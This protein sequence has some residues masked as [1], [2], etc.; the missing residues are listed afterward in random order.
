[1]WNCGGITSNEI[2]ANNGRNPIDG[3]DELF[4]SIQAS[5]LNL[6]IQKTLAQIQ[7]LLAMVAQPTAATTE[8]TTTI[9]TA[10]APIEAATAALQL[11]YDKAASAG[12][13]KAPPI[14]NDDPPPQGGDVID[15]GPKVDGSLVEDA[16]AITPPIRSLQPI[17]DETADR[18]F[19]RETKAV[20]HALTKNS[21]LDAITKWLDGYQTETRQYVIEAL[22]PIATTIKAMGGE[23]NVEAIAD[24]F[25]KDTKADVLKMAAIPTAQRSAEIE[26]MFEGWKDRTERMQNNLLT[27][28][29]DDVSNQGTAI[30]PAS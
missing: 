20:K 5:P 19:R 28:E 2:R 17:I 4:V 26:L 15:D 25:C 6:T 1:L 10:P 30:S 9:T 8:T 16:N 22:A 24:T 14:T 7:Q 13:D 18:L 29:T 11:Q 27:G 3:G 12:E 23:R 21:D